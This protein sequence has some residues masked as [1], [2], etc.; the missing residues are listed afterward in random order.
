M[1]DEDFNVHYDI[2]FKIRTEYHRKRKTRDFILFHF[3]LFVNN[4]KLNRM[5]LDFYS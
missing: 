1:L 5:I 2:L 3:I 4:I